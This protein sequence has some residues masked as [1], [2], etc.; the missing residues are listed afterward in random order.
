MKYEG[1]FMIGRICLRW[2]LALFVSLSLAITVP[3]AH[4]QTKRILLGYSENGVGPFILY[5][6]AVEM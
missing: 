3:A 2:L 5:N 1:D 4:A 6:L